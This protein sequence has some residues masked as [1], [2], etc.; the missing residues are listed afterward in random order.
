MGLN[1][2]PLTYNPMIQISMLQL[3]MDIFKLKRLKDLRNF[4]K[5]PSLNHIH[6][7]YF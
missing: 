5:P 7:F 4:F 3:E 1:P 2:K 6:M